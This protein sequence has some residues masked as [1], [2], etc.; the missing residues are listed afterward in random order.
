ME[1]I[2]KEGFEAVLQEKLKDFVEKQK[3][4]EIKQFLADIPKLY[5]IQISENNGD[6]DEPIEEETKLDANIGKR[7][8]VDQLRP[9]NYGGKRKD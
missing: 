9:W 4:N 5:D 8:P 2:E 3:L 6:H 1:N 7:T